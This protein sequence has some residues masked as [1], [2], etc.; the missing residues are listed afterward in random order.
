ML[1]NDLMCDLVL[2]A[3]PARYRTCKSEIVMAIVVKSEFWADSYAFVRTK[4]SLAKVVA[5]IMNQISMRA[6]RELFAEMLGDA[7][8]DAALDQLK[9]VAHST[10][11]L[12][13]VRTI[14]TVDLINRN[15][16]AGD[17]T[18]LTTRYLTYASRPSTYPTN[19]ALSP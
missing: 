11:E 1:L 5:R 14:E 15:T 17:A 13:G 7:P 16:A 8:P 18:D 2:N 6:D 9:R 12:G 10:T 19:R 3:G 4:S